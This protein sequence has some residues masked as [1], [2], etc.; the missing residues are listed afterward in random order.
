[1][2][3]EYLEWVWVKAV[4]R[5][6]PEHAIYWEKNGIITA[7]IERWE[8]GDHPGTFPGDRPDLL[9]NTRTVLVVLGNIARRFKCCENGFGMLRCL[10]LENARDASIT[11]LG[12]LLRHSNTYRPGMEAACRASDAGLAGI[13]GLLLV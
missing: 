13:N 3:E 9:E 2:D 7:Q 11:T 10:V 8:P 12:S 4:R 6:T 5:R 1:M